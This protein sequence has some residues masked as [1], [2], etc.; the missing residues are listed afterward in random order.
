MMRPT[1]GQWVTGVAGA[2]LLHFVLALYLMSWSDRPEQTAAPAG[3]PAG[4]EIALFPGFGSAVQEVSPEAPDPV[5][6]GAA[7]AGVSDL[8]AEPLPALPAE[9]VA[10]LP[11]PADP[12]GTAAPETAEPVGTESVAALV[13]VEIAVSPD[14]VIIAEALDAARPTEPLPPVETVA[15][16]PLAVP[17]PVPPTVVT[18]MHATE[19]TVAVAPTVAVEPVGPADPVLPER[20]TG[21]VDPLG[22]ETAPV[23]ADAIPV[24]EAIAAVEPV[25][26]MDPLDT[27]D[28]VAAAEPAAAPEVPAPETDLEAI[29]APATAAGA[30]PEAPLEAPAGP[31]TVQADAPAVV[32]S[33]P[34]AVAALLTDPDTVVAT[35]DPMATVAPVDPAPTVAPEGLELVRAVGPETLPSPGPLPVPAPVSLAEAEPAEAASDEPVSAVAPR[36]QATGAAIPVPDMAPG[37]AQPLKAEEIPAPRGPEPVHVTGV[38]PMQVVQAREP[39]LEPAREPATPDPDPPADPA[40][41]QARVAEARPE[42]HEPAPEREEDTSR[43]RPDSDDLQQ[44][45]EPE[46]VARAPGTPVPGIEARYLAA[47]HAALERHKDY[48]RIAQRRREEGTV[49]LLF[50]VDRQGFLLDHTIVRSSGHRSLDNTVEHMIRRAQPLPWIPPEMGVDWV[51]VI[52]PVHFQLEH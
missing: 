50:T 42:P 44:R 27:V 3:D 35:V 38:P 46:I 23:A 34:A 1:R 16:A 39:V 18:P 6:P 36:M 25:T 45:T 19:P 15:A 47:L 21:T 12:A 40:A 32:L 49:L 5:S 22:P 28:P 7:P 24:A 29:V 31:I 33:T 9:T 37:A 20:A 48:P 11:A 43:A 51:R 52:L 41:P 4:V 2:L 13:A 26:A 10:A 14:P 8:P 17:E 30:T